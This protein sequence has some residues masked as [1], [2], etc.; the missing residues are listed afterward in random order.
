MSVFKK[1]NGLEINH[2]CDISIG[3]QLNETSND[4]IPVISWQGT[5]VV[6]SREFLRE[7]TEVLLFAGDTL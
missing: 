4:K 1:E 2:V 5:I 7:I 6:S 3:R